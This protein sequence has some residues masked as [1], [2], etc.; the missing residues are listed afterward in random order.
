MYKSNRDLTG[1]T[2][3]FMSGTTVRGTAQQAIPASAEWREW[4]LYQVELPDGWGNAGDY[5][6]LDFGDAAGYQIELNAITLTALTLAD[7]KKHYV[8]KML[9]VV[10]WSGSRITI[11][12]QEENY[13]KFE[14]KEG[15]PYVR[16]E[17]LAERLPDGVVE[18]SFEYKS[19]KPTTSRFQVFLS[20]SESEARS[21][22][23][24]V[25]PAN[26]SG[27]WKVVTYDLS[28][29]RTN[30][31]EWG[32]PGNNLRL[33]FGSTDDNVGMVMELRNIHLK[34]KD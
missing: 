27:E 7:E 22:R 11:L 33:Q 19:N 17:L 5:L 16:T 2:V 28:T 3:R 31:P 29:L 20:P 18:L 24:P 13:F 4:R 21:L 30:Y 10:G 8:P 14:A 6:Q 15:G 12:E 26:I 25:L 34:Y 1:A 32:S 23:F 9:E